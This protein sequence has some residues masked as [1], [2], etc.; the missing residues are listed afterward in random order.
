MP[1]V[2]PAVVREAAA[3]G[4]LRSIASNLAFAGTAFRAAD[5]P[6]GRGGV[7]GTTRGGSIGQ[8]GSG[9]SALTSSMTA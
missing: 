7:R 3:T 9:A 4:R 8:T 5:G 1:A 2:D 6:E